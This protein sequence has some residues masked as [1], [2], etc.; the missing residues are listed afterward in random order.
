MLKKLIYSLTGL[1]LLPSLCFA[2]TQVLQGRMLT[3]GTATRWLPLSSLTV[4][5]TVGNA[6]VVAGVLPVQGTFS[7]LRVY[8]DE[9]P[10]GTASWTA[11][12]DDTGVD[13][14]I[15]TSIGSATLCTSPTACA[16]TT[17]TYTMN[18][19]AVPTIHVA[20]TGASNPINFFFTIDFTPTNN[21]DTVELSGATNAVPATQGFCSISG[22]VVNT[23]S[24]PTVSLFPETGTLDQFYVKMLAAPGTG[25]TYNFAEQTNNLADA[26]LNF[27]ISNTNTTGNDTTDATSTDAGVSV[28][29]TS[30]LLTAGTG[31]AT[32]AG[33]GYRWRPTNS[34]DFTLQGYSTGSISNT[35]TSYMP[36]SGSVA[37]TQTEASTTEYMDDVTLSKMYVHF[38]TNPGAGKSFTL[39][40]NKN[41]SPTSMTATCTNTQSCNY[42]AS[43]V[44][45]SK[46]DTADITII[47]TGTP[48]ASTM[49]SVAFLA[50]YT[51]GTSLPSHG[52]GII[53]GLLK[54]IAGIAQSG[55]IN[56]MIVGGGGAGQ[57][58]SGGSTP[59]GG[60]GAGGVQSGSTS[61]IGGS[62]PIV[63]GAG[64][65]AAQNPGAN[66]SASSFD[67]VTAGA[68]QGGGQGTTGTGGTSG[69]PQ[70]NAG[71]AKSTNDGSGGG[72][73]GSVGGAANQGTGT[74]GAGG[75]GFT[76]SISGSSVT[77][78]CG[79]G[80]GGVNAI[81]S[82][83][84]TNAGSGSSGAQFANQN[85]AGSN[86]EVILSAPSGTI[87]ATGGSFTTSGGNDIWTFTSS[88]TWIVTALSGALIIP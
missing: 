37:T 27:N 64:G 7:N 35:L 63:I 26:L 30:A 40:L 77:Y 57:N 50:N 5:T 29:N 47:P 16:D 88:G 32:G 49:L 43:S 10:G 28:F 24:T 54:I 34:G 65:I 83:S 22:G 44:I 1:L 71:G 74:G 4:L 25:N 18:A 45:F 15:T 59:A 76:S 14:S 38:R 13:K 20:V 17:H 48:T 69:T 62:Y 67:G 12:L 8:T 78:A 33:Y 42:T 52:L 73:E 75:T 46:G 84:C 3:G 36:V 2:S 61:I 55:T 60:G 85:V 21:G 80:G 31:S 56:Y 51:P 23:T 41:G 79:G 86:G 87:S 82:V 19:G 39:T 58:T 68:G 9:V 6:Q 11:T 81:G 53:S 66:G 70:S 72:G